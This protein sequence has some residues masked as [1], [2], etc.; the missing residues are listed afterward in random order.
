MSA[1]F[2]VIKCE[3]QSHQMSVN[4][5]YGNKCRYHMNKINLAHCTGVKRGE[6]ER[7]REKRVAERGK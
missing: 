2:V 1:L 5:Y 4:H 6:G 3:K 7:L